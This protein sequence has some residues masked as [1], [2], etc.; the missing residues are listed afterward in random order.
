MVAHETDEPCILASEAHPKLLCSH[1]KALNIGGS[2]GVKEGNETSLE[3]MFDLVLEWAVSKFIRTWMSLLRLN[4][5][6]RDGA[7]WDR[8]CLQL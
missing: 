6:T 8:W 2:T 4:A 3:F 7:W 5:L 1:L